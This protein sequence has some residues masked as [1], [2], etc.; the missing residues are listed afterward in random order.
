MSM[1]MC[2]NVK[3]EQEDGGKGKGKKREREGD[4]VLRWNENKKA[5]NWY[6]VKSAA[7]WQTDGDNLQFT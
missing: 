6:F 3:E 7:S 2:V 4:N 5:H 1:R